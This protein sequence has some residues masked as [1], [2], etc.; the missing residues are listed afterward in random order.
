MKVSGKKIL[1]ILTLV[2]LGVSL[3]VSTAQAQKQ[4]PRWFGPFQL[5]SE[6]AVVMGSGTIAAD[7]YGYVHAFWVE[8]GVVSGKY[9]LQYA[10]FD[11]TTWSNPIDIFISPEAATFG[12][13]FPPI[14]TADGT[15]HLFWTLSTQGPLVHMS[16]PA[17][18]ALSAL[19]W[20]RAPSFP[21]PVFQ[22]VARQDAAGVLHVV[23][24]NLV[25]ADPGLYY[26][27]SVDGGKNFTTEI[28]LDPSIPSNYGPSSLHFEIDPADGVMHIVWR[29]EEKLGPATFEGKAQMY[30]R[31][32]DGGQTWSDPYTFD[33]ADE[34]PGEL[35]GDALVF[36]VHQGNAVVVWAGTDATEREYAYSTDA[37]VTWKGPLRTFGGLQGSAAGDSMVVDGAGDFHWMGQVRYPQ[38]LYEIGWDGTRWG[39]PGLIYLISST[40]LDPIGDRIHIHSVRTAV[41]R[42][43]QLV[44]I[45]TDP[46]PNTDRALYAIHRTFDSIPPRDILPTP[47]PSATP[48]PF[49]TPTPNTPPKTPT[50]TLPPFGTAAPESQNSPGLDLGI[51]ILAVI[52]LIAAVV[53]FRIAG[54]ARFRKR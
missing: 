12:F 43:N 53:V 1:V 26:M 4:D 48:T 9:I 6:E 18:N 30:M 37:G 46:P 52:L 22:L 50:P 32:V 29:Y 21:L 8:G 35:R 40:A 17:T 33:I 39:L 42:G 5:S 36:G 45:F 2:L 23:F 27:R 11:G 41:R 49:Q 20:T 16:A 14:V 15:L 54:A 47:L 44:T 19:N 51:S 38:G 13:L 31:S 10:R 24:S 7:E 3:I 25:G 34:D 28:W